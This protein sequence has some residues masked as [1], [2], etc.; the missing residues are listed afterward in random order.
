MPAPRTDSDSL[1]SLAEALLTSKLETIMDWDKC[2]NFA[3]ILP[4]LSDEQTTAIMKALENE[5]IVFETVTIPTADQESMDSYGQGLLPSFLYFGFSAVVT[6][7]SYIIQNG[8]TPRALVQN[9][10]TRELISAQKTSQH[11]EKDQ[12]RLQ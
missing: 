3:G 10:H 11:N 2:C 5:R 9:P 12:S 4:S 1:N 7:S 6:V 8:T